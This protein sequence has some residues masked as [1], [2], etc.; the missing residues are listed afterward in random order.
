MAQ[1]LHQPV[2]VEP[3]DTEPRSA[4]VA[5]GMH[6]PEAL[7]EGVL[8]VVPTYNERD[9]L[10]AFV[11]A[12]RAQAPRAHLLIVDDNSPDGT[13]ELASA[14]AAADAGVSVLRRSGKLGLGTAY[15]AGFRW[16][17]ERTFEWFLEMDADFSHDPAHLPAI[18]DELAAGAQLVIGSRNVAG[19]GVKGWGLGRRLLSQGGSLYSRAVLG[20]SVR[21]F[22]S[23]YKGFSRQA[24]EAL[25]LDSVHANGYAFQI[26]MTYRTVR[27]GLRVVETPITFVD[28]R[29][30]QSKMDRRIF[31]EAV[32]VVWRLR[33]DAWR[34]R[35]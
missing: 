24:L 30:G 14:L 17:L 32:A 21:D 33:L 12:L 25:D 7:G 1:L 6:P 18:F 27:A 19:G 22:T 5:I 13:G 26:E 34:R 11:A 23:G 9:N 10:M 2:V 8:I 16:G 3:E 35:L 4:R 31:L 20:V 28:R 15:V 29:V